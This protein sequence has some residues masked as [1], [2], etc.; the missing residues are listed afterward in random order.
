MIRRAADDEPGRAAM[1]RVRPFI[2]AGQLPS[3]SP[4]DEEPAPADGHPTGPRPFVLTAGRVSGED[5]DIGLETQVTARAGGAAGQTL[6]L[7]APEQR[8]IVLLCR[9]PL[10][11]AEISAQ[12]RLHLGVA[13]ILVGD[14]RAA[15]HVE[16]HTDAEDPSANP[17]LILRVIN[18][19]RGLS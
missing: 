13:R 3:E 16:V 18:G 6:A 9:E 1:P 19:L 5:P 7:L 2:A 15:G 4:D 12:L 8:E 14:L 17:D 11:V 10:S